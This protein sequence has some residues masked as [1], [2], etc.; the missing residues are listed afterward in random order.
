MVDCREL[1]RCHPLSLCPICGFALFCRCIPLV[2][3]GISFGSR[4]HLSKSS[5]G[6]LCCLCSVSCVCLVLLVHGA[7]FSSPCSRC[8]SHF[9]GLSSGKNLYVLSGLLFSILSHM[10]MN[11]GHVRSHDACPVFIQLTHLCLSGFSSLHSAV[12]CPCPHVP[13]VSSPSQFAAMCR[14]LSFWHLRH[15]LGSFLSLL[16][17]VHFP[18]MISPSR[19]LMFA[20]SIVMNF[21]IRCAVCCPG[22]CLCTGLTHLV[23]SSV[24]EGILESRSIFLVTVPS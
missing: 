23:D 19:M 16:A 18:A 17:H 21:A 4:F 12:L 22:V 5:M 15:R 11:L 10:A 7:F 1:G 3:W 9:H 6:S 14:V 24:L 13:H 8:C 2:F 20:A